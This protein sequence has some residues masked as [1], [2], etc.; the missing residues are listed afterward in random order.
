M[1]KVDRIG[2]GTRAIMWP[3]LTALNDHALAAAWCGEEEKRR[4]SQLIH[5]GP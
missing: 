1:L 3:E 4:L 5:R 2:H